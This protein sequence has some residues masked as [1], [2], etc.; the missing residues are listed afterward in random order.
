[1]ATVT[2]SKRQQTHT[3]DTYE[4]NS[5]VTVGSNIVM[6]A[7]GTV[8]GVDV[9]ARDAILT[10][11]TATSNAALP[12]AG[13]TMTGALNTGGNAFGGSYLGINS[14]GVTQWGA[15]RGILTWG[16]GFASIYSGSGSA[17]WIGAGGT[18]DK[19]IILDGST[20]AVNKPITTNSTFDGV[21]IAARN[22]ILT[23]TTAT[24]NAA[25]PKAGGTMT[26]NLTI[27]STYPRINLTDT[28]NNP[29]WSIINADG[30]LHFYDATNAVNRLKVNSTGI[31]VTGD[32]TFAGNITTSG[33]SYISAAFNSSNYMRIEGNSSGGVLKG[34][35]GGVNTTLI[36][37]Y[38]DSF[39][40]GGNVGIGTTS[41]EANLHISKDSA[42]GSAYERLIIDGV[43]QSTTASGSS[44]AITFK[45]SGNV[46]AGAVGGYGNGTVGGIGVWGGST[47]SGSPDVFVKAGNVGIGT[48]NPQS[49]LEVVDSGETSLKVRDAG[50]AEIQLYQQSSSSYII[51]TNALQ[52]YTG[53]SF[54]SVITSAGD[55]GIGTASPSAKLDVVGVSEFNGDLNVNDSTLTITAAAPNLLFVVPSGGLDSR[56][57]NDGSGNFI[58]GHG[59]NSSNPTERLRINSSGDV[60][61]GTTSP[62][63]KLHI[64]D[65]AAT[66]TGLLVTGGGVGGPLATF[67]R[68]VGGS[69]SIQ[70]NSSG[71]DP[72]IKF[73]SSANTF[74]LGTNSS[75]FEICDN[76]TVGANARLSI[77]SAGNVGIGTTAPVAKLHIKKAQSTS[78]FTDPFLMLHPSATTNE[79]GLTSM[80]LST[81]TVSSAYGFSVNAWR[82]SG[83]DT[84]TIKSHDGT[85]N[86]TDRL[87]IRK[88]GYVGIG[89]T[90]PSSKLQVV[91]TI[92]GTTK[93]FLID[94]PKTGGQLQYG[95][96][97]SNEHSVCVRGNSNQEE[98][99]LPEEWE[100]LV[101]EDSVTV[102]LTS[103]GQA[104]NL[105]ILEHNNI[106]VKVGGLEAD[107]KYSYIIYGTRK[108]VA[109]LEVNIIK[110]SGE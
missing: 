51:T 67:T 89:T 86:G 73:A 15:N 21:D 5:S 110:A 2:S 48:T 103:I 47:N 95:A 68:D 32:A 102:Q 10:L 107:G 50:G 30:A 37:S 81:T 66:G 100:W 39:F 101:H 104:Q 63:T 97:E 80:F 57:F 74:S 93:N 79:T 71:S 38:G 7:S 44:Q 42:N 35:D 29:D 18:S 69:G 106:R 54:R 70:I 98:I 14:S 36:R 65:D 41:P 75:T 84:F 56:I 49:N 60:G 20:I 88:N 8:D 45:G 9:S 3:S 25:L 4:S 61:I 77:T 105:F 99:E 109:P 92:T 94:D 40:N 43:S 96:V 1:M 27:S 59:T 55:F 83:N 24:A 28:N 26:G 76:G 85:S 53:G 12:K 87:V 52:F 90:S 13:G 33:N 22:A 91:G 64:D 82:R 19:S 78:A 16:T 62:T 17:L 108:D 34:L 46:Y 72:Q 23:S 31:D 58:I 6:S 11:T